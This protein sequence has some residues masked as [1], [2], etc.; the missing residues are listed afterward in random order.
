MATK[1]TNPDTSEAAR[2]IMVRLLLLDP[3]KFPCFPGV[4]VLHAKRKRGR[5]LYDI[6]RKEGLR[7]QKIYLPHGQVVTLLLAHSSYASKIR[8][9][10]QKE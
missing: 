8:L 9:V 5:L 4:F 2:I 10:K 7:E 3:S 6:N 1:T